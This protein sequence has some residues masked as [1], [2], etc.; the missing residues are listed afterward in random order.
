MKNDKSKKLSKQINTICDFKSPTSRN[1]FSE[2][3]TDP[4]NVTIITLTT[5]NTHLAG[6]KLTA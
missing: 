4:T 1:A 6:Q 3:G 2:T 5:V